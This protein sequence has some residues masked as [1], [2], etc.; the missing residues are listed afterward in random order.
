MIRRHARPRPEPVEQLRPTSTREPGPRPELRYSNLELLPA[1]CLCESHVVHVTREA[2]KA[3]AV[4]CHKCD[5]APICPLCAS[6]HH[7]MT[8]R[9]SRGLRRRRSSSGCA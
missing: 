7:P 1:L 8:C 2:V 4:Y 6:P 9:F 3:G 5:P